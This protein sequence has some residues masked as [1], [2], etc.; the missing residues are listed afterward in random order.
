MNRYTSLLAAAALVAAPSLAQ[1]HFQLV[2]TPE[3]L[4]EK[5]GEVELGLIF[6]HP[7][8][9]GHAMDMGRP[10]QVFAVNHGKRIDLAPALVAKRFKGAGNEADAWAV[11]LPVKKM[12]DY[13]VAV[14]PAPYL[15]GSEDIFIQQIAKSFLNL[16]ELPT[17]WTEPLGLPTEIV[18]LTKPTNIPTGSTFSGCVLSA[19]K[20]VAGAEIE[21]EYIAATPDLTRFAATAPSVS[22]P[23]GGALVVTSDA[24]GCF[25]YGLPKAGDWGFAALGTGPETSFEG[26]ELSQDAVIWVRARDLN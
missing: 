2:Y 20:P 11:T 9:N 13:V 18:P 24:N 21:V 10:E 25:T 3:P 15:E 1:A 12:G 4:L 6:W 14:V 7:F 8:D 19:G 23:P 26:K 5:P 22:P 17:D 16:G